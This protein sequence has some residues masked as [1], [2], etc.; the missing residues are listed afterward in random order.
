M[1]CVQEMLTMSRP[2]NDKVA[3]SY[4]MVMIIVLILM[5]FRLLNDK[6]DF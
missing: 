6:K 2:L 1:M 4:D 5:M 3:E